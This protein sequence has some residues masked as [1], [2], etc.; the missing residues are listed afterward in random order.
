MARKKKVF[1]Y[2]FID[3]EKSFPSSI[4]VICTQT[5]EK[6]RMYHKQLARLIENKYR[7]NY[8][9]FKAT[10]IKKGN[11]P[12]ENNRDINGEYNT[13][14]E[15]YRQYLVSSYMFTKNDSSMEDSTRSGKLNFLSEC[16]LKRYK[17][18]LDEV[19][20]LAEL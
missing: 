13:A 5:K 4:E 18:S 10:Y 14:P 20:K 2:Q 8:S 19:V 6:V 16:Y 17:N 12:E 15:G 11:K 9:V 7:N 3:C 1:N